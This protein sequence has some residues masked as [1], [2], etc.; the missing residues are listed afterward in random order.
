M[1]RRAGL[2]VILALSL[3]AGAADARKVIRYGMVELPR[4]T[5][6]PFTMVGPSGTMVWSGLFDGLTA[7]EEDGTL[8]PALAT[9]WASDGPQRWRFTLRRGVRF[10]EGTPFDASAVVAT[11]RW[12]LGA[13]G[14]AT[15]VGAEFT[16]VAAVDSPDAETVVF[17]LNRPDAIFPVRASLPMIVEPRRW[18][19]LGPVGFARA[20]I[21]TG[22]FVVKE[23]KPGGAALMLDAVA[24][25][26]RAPRADAVEMTVIPQAVG[27][28]Q[29]MLTGAID[30]TES[31]AFDDVATLREAGLAVLVAPTSQV[32]SLA[33]VTVGRDSH[34][35]ADKRVRQAL[36][37]AV[38]KDLMAR[39]LSGGIAVPMAQAA[40]PGMA[41][42]N[43]DVTAYPHD[44]ARARAL[45]AEAGYGN[46]FALSIIAV[47]GFLPGDEAIYQRAAED[48]RR[49]GLTVS[50]QAVP[51]NGLYERLASGDWTGV[52]MFGLS[53]Q[54]RPFHDPLRAMRT[55][56]CLAPQPFFCDRALTPLLEAA[57]AAPDAA[58]REGLLRELAIRFKDTAPALYLLAQ[59]EVIGVSPRLKHVRRRNRT[60]VMHEIEVVDP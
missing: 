26:W 11:Y 36:N 5:G 10:A 40:V 15:E 55:F 39:A 54:G 4:G 25:S 50:L 16:H 46:G 3:A 60:L 48:L 49:I 30:V 45:L 1:N 33:F 47:G 43:P 8:H 34:P 37:Y 44:P 17:H 56:S 13:E 21:G 32:M 7:L 41:G 23:W 6:N 38:D 14:R 59:A 18:A 22:S 20:P 19:D 51:L 52:D 28:L 9:A 35:L 12:L 57:D 2:A 53:F 31:I 29:A 24:G 27:R 42:H 58:V